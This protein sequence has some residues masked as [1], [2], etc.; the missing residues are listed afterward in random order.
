MLLPAG[1]IPLPGGGILV[2]GSDVLGSPPPFT[3]YAL[4]PAD[5]AGIL[6]CIEGRCCE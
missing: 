3:E 5:D 2:I 1:G 6:T 4:L